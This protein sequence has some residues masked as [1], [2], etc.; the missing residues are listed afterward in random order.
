MSLV[1]EI[2]ESN[3]VR[4]TIKNHF[5]VK[6]SVS[7][8]TLEQFLDVYDCD[9]NGK[10]NVNDATGRLF[11]LPFDDESTQVDSEYFKKPILRIDKIAN[12]LDVYI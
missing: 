6:E 9:Y 1:D 3:N 10:V 11:T 7:K 4:E 5:A 2:L 8:I 12:E